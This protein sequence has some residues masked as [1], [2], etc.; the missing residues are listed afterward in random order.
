MARFTEAER[1]VVWDR[2]QAGDS[3]RLIARELGRQSS[4][5]RTLIEN[6]GG[7]RPLARRPDRR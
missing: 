7:V 2:W 1:A 6:T 4:S 5:V 3:M